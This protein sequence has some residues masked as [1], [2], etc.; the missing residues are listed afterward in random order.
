VEHAAF[1]VAVG[2][3]D[4]VEEEGVKV[5]R[6][7]QVAVGAL[8]GGHGTG[9]AIWQVALGVAVAIPLGYRVGEEAQHLT[10]QASRFGRAGGLWSAPSAGLADNDD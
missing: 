7:S 5:R 6:K 8:D 2:A 3:V 1:A 10:R 9:F 4:T